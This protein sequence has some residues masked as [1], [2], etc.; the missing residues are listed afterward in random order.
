MCRS[1]RLNVLV[2][3]IVVG[4]VL[5]IFSKL[6]IHLLYFNLTKIL[7]ILHFIGCI[8]ALQWMAYAIGN[9]INNKFFIVIHN[10]I[11]WIYTNKSSLF[12]HFQRNINRSENISWH[13]KRKSIKYSMC[14]CVTYTN[15]CFSR[16]SIFA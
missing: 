7:Y 12:L 8:I 5:L 9:F 3:R 13:W 1:I 2:I 14:I 10:W 6:Q 16:Q 4:I 15:T 11:K